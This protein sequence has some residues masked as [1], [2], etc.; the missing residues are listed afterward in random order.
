MLCTI[1]LALRKLA[2]NYKSHETRSTCSEKKRSRCCNSAFTSP[3]IV[4]IIQSNFLFSISWDEDLGAR[5]TLIISQSD[6]NI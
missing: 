6:K 5:E 4:Y 2:T 1:R 3:Q